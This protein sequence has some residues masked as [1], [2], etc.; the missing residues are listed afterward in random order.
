MRSLPAVPTLM[1]A[2][3]ALLADV[4]QGDD[5]F[6]KALA[7]NEGALAFLAAPPSEAVHHHVNRIAIT[8]ESLAT[9]WVGMDQCHHHIDP[10]PRAEIVYTEGRI[11]KL[12]IV[13]V[14]GIGSARVESHS[15]QLE[16][17]E[18]NATLC[19]RAETLGLA[20]EHGGYVLRNGPFM[21][22]FLDGFYPMHV[23]L[24]V[25]YPEQLELVDHFPS[26][27]AGVETRYGHDRVT[28]DVWFEGIL[29]TRFFFRRR[30]PS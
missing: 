24:D 22:R 12:E 17:I 26:A 4:D 19:I 21:R 9:G 29:E 18:R 30:E 2:S 1:I 13:S 14:E 6:E 5:P 23:T 28:L 3:A 10:V 7:V 11:R 25:R 8:A 15:V 16:D 27:P 20:A